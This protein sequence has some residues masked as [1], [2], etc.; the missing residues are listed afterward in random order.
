M[1]TV[2]RFCTLI[3]G[4]VLYSR[5]TRGVS[6]ARSNGTSTPWYSTYLRG[7]EPNP[8]SIFLCSHQLTQQRAYPQ[9][10]LSSMPVELLSHASKLNIV[11]MLDSGRKM[12]CV[13]H[14]YAKVKRFLGFGASNCRKRLL[15]VNARY[16]TQQLCRSARCPVSERSTPHEARHPQ[17]KRVKLYRVSYDTIPPKIEHPRCESSEMKVNWTFRSAAEPCDDGVNVTKFYII[18]D[19]CC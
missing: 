1:A 9:V 8:Y 11:V 7:Y 15:D 2:K 12:P 6:N 10:R 4:I 16:H 5:Q 14:I 13:Y 17:H 3:A 19:C 18:F